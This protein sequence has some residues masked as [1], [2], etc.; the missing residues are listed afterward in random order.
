[1]EYLIIILVAIAIVAIYFVISQNTYQ[2]TKKELNKLPNSYK[3]VNN[4]TLESDG[5]SFKIDY[6]VIGKPG[7]YL[8]N[9]IDR[10][11]VIIGDESQEKWKET[12]GDKVEEFNNP[13]FKN[14]KIRSLVRKKIDDLS[15]K[16]PMHNLVLFHK[17]ANLNDLFSESLTIRANAL[18]NYISDDKQILNEEQINNIFEKFKA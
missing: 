1:M 2:V 6:V 3:M 14:L 18:Q 17:K 4:V 11:G 8:L 10:K 12:N 7:I 9:I 13:I 5:E 15:A 16:I